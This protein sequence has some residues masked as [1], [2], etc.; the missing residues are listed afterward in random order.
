MSQFTAPD[1]YS[2]RMNLLKRSLACGAAASALLLGSASSAQDASLEVVTVTGYRASLAGA[3]DVKRASAE[4]IDAINAEDIAAFPDA[5]L[6]EALQRLPGVAVDRENGE[7]RT[8][9]VRGLGANFTRVTL[10]GLQT[11]ST[12]GASSGSGV[13][14]NRDRGFDFNT[15]AS[16]L[17][18]SLTVQKSASA[19]TEEGSLGATVGL[20]TPRPFDQGGKDRFV[21]GAQNAW[22]EIGKP[23]NPRITA[24][25][26]TTF[27]GGKVGVLAS[28]AYSSKGVMS[29]SYTRQPGTPDYMYRAQMFAN[30]P[31]VGLDNSSLMQRGGFAA[32]TGTSCDGTVAPY[33]QG[34]IPGNNI[35]NMDY[36]NALRGSDAA[37]YATVNTPQGWTVSDTNTKVGSTT[38]KV[39]GPGSTI[40]IPALAGSTHQAIYQSKLGATNSVQWQIKDQTLLTVDGLFSSVY[41][42]TLN[43]GISV[44][45]LNRN[46]TNSVLNTASAATSDTSL[47][48]IYFNCAAQSST[49]AALGGVQQAA[50]DCGQQIY[51]GSLV[52]GTA[53]SYNP[54]NLDTYDYYTSAYSAA[55]YVPGA[56]K[57][58]AINQAIVMLGRPATR[59]MGAKVSNGVANYLALDN[60]DFSS[61]TDEV[62]YSTQFEQL[63][64]NFKSDFTDWFKVNITAGWSRSYN[65]QE[66]TLVNDNAMNIGTGTG[67]GY[68]IYDNT[69]GGDMP[70]ISYGFNTS[71]PSKW[72]FVKGYSTLRHFRFLTLNHYRTLTADTELRLS[73]QFTFKFGGNARIFDFS[74]AYY[75]RVIR[76]QVNPS[77][78]ELGVT[79]AQMSQV[80]TWGRGLDVK[81]GTTTS[82]IVPNLDAYKSVIGFD[83]DCVNKY[84]D[85]RIWNLYNPTS[86]GLAGQTFS[87]AEHSK[88]I[89]GQLD[90]KD[91]MIF[92][93]PLRGNIGLRYVITDV[94]S[95]GHALAGQ[96]IT[97]DSHYTDVL[98]SANFV[99]SLSDTMMLRASTGLVMARPSL[100]LMAPS[101]TAFS[102]PGSNT[103]DMTQ[104][105]SMTYGNTHL[106]PYRAKTIDIGWEWYFD[107]GAVLAVAG[108]VKWVKNNPQQVISSGNLKDF[109]PQST[110]DTIR[111]QYWAQCKSAGGTD[112]NNS[113][114]NIAL[115]A[116]NNTWY[117]D[118]NYLT[119]AT[120]PI[121]GPGGSLKGI[122]ITY[123]QPLDF[124]PAFLGGQGFGV[125]A[126]YTKITSKQH[127]IINATLSALTMADGPWMG[128]SPDAF[129]FTLY[130]DARKWSGRVSTAFRSSYLYLFPIAGG[131][132]AVGYGN[133]P[134]MNDFGYSRNTMNVDAAF[135]YNISDNM[136][137][138]LDA[139]NLTNQ[140]DR[141]WAYAGEPQATNYASTGRQVYLGFRLKY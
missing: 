67:D 131:N 35:T 138:T 107:K 96:P 65:H 29:D 112:D 27:F 89:Y 84:G 90:F 70:S 92:E 106:K 105:G 6:A 88:S 7:G 109:L 81:P 118:N 135:S 113:A 32:P 55:H 40:L 137:M 85:W 46:N 9:T 98:P 44:T 114:A 110:I 111:S 62:H 74:T 121:N 61:Q 17:F 127:Y 1:T 8:I 100:G 77:F 39:T 72:T 97:D 129:N 18:G 117:M 53:F 11:L 56:T 37:A 21:F 71:D 43:Q 16:E 33:T 38:S 79:S 101:L 28:I 51:G 134:L 5:N 48:S 49:N 24:L 36:C 119:T 82:W 94:H 132:D 104:V 93:N 91:V 25:G 136:Q 68:Y 13:A 120:Q 26:S 133:S 128:A 3:L 99:Y 115:T 116:C 2:G 141:R 126:N 22:Y 31:L 69:Q 23:F 57:T 4:M 54:Y 45:G 66:G 80:V 10:N 34:V 41:Q 123:Q 122:E 52:S 124:I 60:L 76:E 86:S 12:A 58:N 140:P 20:S 125:N 15:F 87:V 42:T 19:S 75:T 103:H 64:A 139:L 14:P 102:T 95:V 83:C 130:Y 50:I 63:S 73:D 30:G 78:E 47:R 59:V 108:F